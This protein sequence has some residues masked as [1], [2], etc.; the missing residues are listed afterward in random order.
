MNE[1]SLYP[2]KLKSIFVQFFSQLKNY[3]LL[4]V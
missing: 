4:N 2:L 1:N 3:I